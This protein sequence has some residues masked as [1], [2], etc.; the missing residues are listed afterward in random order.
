MCKSRNSSTAQQLIS[1]SAHQLISISAVVLVTL[2]LAG[3]EVQ[4]RPPLVRAAAA[5]ET[6]GRPTAELRALQAGIVLADRP[7]YACF[8]L[9]D[10]GLAEGAG[11]ES[12]QSSCVCV[13]PSLVR[14]LAADQQS[15]TGVLLEFVP[16]PVDQ[17]AALGV[18]PETRAAL[19]AVRVDLQLAD[20]RTHR[21]TVNL[22]HTMP[23]AT[24]GI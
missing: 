3:C 14:Y 12:M 7:G 9:S 2:G 23:A 4:P 21:F 8:S 20:G 5:G 16:E 18:H 17:T 15:R 19:L 24:E 1:S 10:I 6:A 22:L 11:V 13:K